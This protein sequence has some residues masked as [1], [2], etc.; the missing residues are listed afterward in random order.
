VTQ[1]CSW[2]TTLGGSLSAFGKTLMGVGVVPQLGSGEHNTFLSYV[3]VVGF[4]CDALGG[5]FGHLWAADQAAVVNMIE[6]SGGDTRWAAKIDVPAEVA[7][8]A[9]K[10]EGAPW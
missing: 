9:E 4:I 5:F 6:K 7:E 1:A 10:P 8:V 3:A 2:K